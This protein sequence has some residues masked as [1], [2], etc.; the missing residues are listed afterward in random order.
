MRKSY[1]ELEKNFREKQ[2][3][4]LEKEWMLQKEVGIIFM[5]SR[6]II[7]K[8]I[9]Y[10]HLFDGRWRKTLEEVTK[11]LGGNLLAPCHAPPQTM[12]RGDCE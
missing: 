10:K 9:Q 2:Q 11:D 1:R 7:V 3:G 6:L 5:K 8:V 12:Q 4:D